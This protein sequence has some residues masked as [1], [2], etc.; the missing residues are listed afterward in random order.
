MLPQVPICIY[1]TY[2]DQ[3]NNSSDPFIFIIVIRN[4]EIR[5]SVNLDHFESRIFILDMKKIGVQNVNLIV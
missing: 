2:K 1:H 4:D 3:N 5:S